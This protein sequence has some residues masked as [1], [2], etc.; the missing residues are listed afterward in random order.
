MA[1]V[2]RFNTI[3]VRKSSIEAK[4]PGGLDA[5]RDLYLPTNA[6]FYFE[7]QH[8]IGHTSMGAFHEVYDRLTANGLAAVNSRANGAS[9]SRPNRASAKWRLAVSN[10]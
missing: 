7:D 8:L 10:G 1:L 5:Y 3:V 2:I 4:Y 6:N 9:D